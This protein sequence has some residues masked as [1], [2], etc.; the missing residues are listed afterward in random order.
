[1]VNPATALLAFWIYWLAPLNILYQRSTLLDPMAV[2][3]AMVS[4]YCLARLLGTGDSVERRG[5]GRA[6]GLRFVCFAIATWL[7]GMMKAL[8]LW[9]AVLLFGQA[10]IAR[11]FK[12]NRRIVGIVAVFA[13]VGACFL[14]WN[15]YAGRINRA[16][17]FVEAVSGVSGGIKP[18]SHLGF[19]ALL[20]PNF[21]Y[22]QI[23]HMPNW[24]LGA[25]GTMLYPI[26]LLAVWRKTCE[27]ARTSILW[28]LIVVPPTYLLL[29][30]DINAQEFY[31]LIITPFLAIVSGYGLRWLGLLAVA[32]F[33]KLGS[34]AD[35]MLAG[36]GA[37]LVAASVLIYCVWF[38]APLV[39][40]QLL[41]FQELCVGKFEPWAPAMLFVARDIGGADSSPNI[42]EFLYAAR[43]WGY[44]HLVNSAEEA[45][46]KFETLAPVFPR[47]EFVVFYGIK[48]PE[49][50]PRSFH[51]EIKDDSRRFYVFQRSPSG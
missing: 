41:K 7:V 18:T 2:F 23:F 12:P 39:N 22:T 11:R 37:A 32:K 4:F 8:Y 26:G 44:A 42:P 9:P 47:L 50:M 21:Y 15:S 36:A 29:F 35:A 49:W 13:A 28:L 31:S 3:C 38:R 51:L 40:A 17:P 6:E 20:S 45:R 5:G 48:P 16:S 19:S 1:L 27:G 46:P 25:L 34:A 43:L 33:P 10:V 14:A 24:W 30:A